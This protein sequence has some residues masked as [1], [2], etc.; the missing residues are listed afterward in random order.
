MFA[1]D[2]IR[3]CHVPSVFFFLSLGAKLDKKFAN[4]TKIPKFLIINIMVKIN[5]IRYSYISAIILTFLL[6]L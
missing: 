4:F 2:Y 6:V 1:L 5:V 3:L